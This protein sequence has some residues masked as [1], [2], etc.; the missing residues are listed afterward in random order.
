MPIV[1]GREIDED[2]RVFLVRKAGKGPFAVK[3]YKN[4]IVETGWKA[5]RRKRDIIRPFTFRAIQ[6]LKSY[7]RLN[8]SSP[9]NDPSAISGIV[10]GKTEIRDIAI[11]DFGCWY[12]VE[13][14]DTG[15]FVRVD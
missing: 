15:R 11:T 6:W 5:E 4:P 9:D 2:Q 13:F 10:R 12:K 3:T 14:V 1:G 8:P 7:Q